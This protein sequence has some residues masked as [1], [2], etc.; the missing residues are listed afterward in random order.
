MMMF[1]DDVDVTI[2]NFSKYWIERFVDIVSCHG[3]NL[4]SYQN[5]MKKIR[6][7]SKPWKMNFVIASDYCTPT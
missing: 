1:Y 4:A 7:T 6:E 5:C 3:E 2:D